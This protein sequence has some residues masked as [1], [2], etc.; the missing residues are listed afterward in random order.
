[1][2]GTTQS[3]MAKQLFDMRNRSRRRIVITLWLHLVCTVILSCSAWTGRL[4]ELKRNTYDALWHNRRDGLVCKQFYHSNF[5]GVPS[6]ALYVVAKKN[7]EKETE[8]IDRAADD[9]ISFDRPYVIRSA[10]FADLGTAARLLTDGFFANNTNF[11]TYRLERL[12]TFL[13]LESTFPSRNDELHTMIVACRKT[14]GLVLGFA[15]LDA[16]P[17]TIKD[18]STSPSPRPYMCN[19]VVDQKWRRQGIATALVEECERRAR[20]WGEKE[21]FLKVREGNAAAIAMYQSMGYVTQST[22]YDETFKVFN[23]L[24][25]KSFLT[26]NNVVEMM[27]CEKLYVSSQEGVD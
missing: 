16:R 6:T 13:S 17:T 26:L 24:L 12:K 10:V 14:D 22:S 2:E 21:M 8:K 25:K 3:G 20:E 11:I 5:P 19:L 23:I 4:D 1:M 18:P 9:S 27:K 15:E 7:R